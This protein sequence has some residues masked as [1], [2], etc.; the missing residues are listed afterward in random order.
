MGGASSEVV[1]TCDMKVLMPYRGA[2]VDHELRE[3]KGAF[4]SAA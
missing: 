2:D 1:C 3:L 4:E